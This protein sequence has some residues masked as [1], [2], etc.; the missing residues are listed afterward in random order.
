MSMVI[1]IT[2]VVGGGLEMVNI[3]CI[4]KIIFTIVLD[5]VIR[6]KYVYG[7]E[8]IKKYAEWMGD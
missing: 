7:L 1:T 5:I 2:T 4:L 8:I 6:N 3:V